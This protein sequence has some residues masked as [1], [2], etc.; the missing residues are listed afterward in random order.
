[1]IE[2]SID[3]R[4]LNRY[5]ANSDSMAKRVLKS[6]SKVVASTWKLDMLHTKTG[7]KGKIKTKDGK[8]HYPSLPGH[9]PARED[10][11]L[12]NSLR[13]ELVDDG[14]DFFGADYGLDLDQNRNRPFI[15]AGLEAGKR[16]ISGIARAV[17]GESGVD[18]AAGSF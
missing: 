2:L 11:D 18:E 17:W 8:K 10:G 6:V 12:I 4:K 9:P 14:A 7:G 16:D 15:D 1:M 5:I 13:F 3:D